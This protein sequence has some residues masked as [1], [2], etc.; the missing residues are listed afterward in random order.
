MWKTARSGIDY[1][2]V[3]NEC[4]FQ[5]ER[6]DN[7]W[8]SGLFEKYRD[9]KEKYNILV[10]YAKDLKRMAGEKLVLRTYS[11]QIRKGNDT[12]VSIAKALGGKWTKKQISQD[13]KALVKSK[14]LLRAGE[15]YRI[16]R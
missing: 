4:T 12:E 5:S 14:R 3:F 1:R 6:T 9:L 16:P 8:E 7:I 13:L 10:P 2:I 15:H 11:R